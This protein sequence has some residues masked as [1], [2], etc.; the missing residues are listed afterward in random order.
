MLDYVPPAAR[1]QLD[2]AYARLKKAQDQKQLATRQM[3]DSLRE[4]DQAKLKSL[5]KD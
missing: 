2:A 4:Q 1:E 3:M 5:F